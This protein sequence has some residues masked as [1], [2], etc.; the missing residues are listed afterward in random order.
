MITNSRLCSTSEFRGIFPL[1]LTPAISHL[2]A[3]WFKP[4]ADN[5]YERQRDADNFALTLCSGAD[6][7][8]AGYLGDCQ[9]TEGDYLRVFQAYNSSNSDVAKGVTEVHAECP[10]G[11]VVQP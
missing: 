1:S 6:E 9:I 3:T 8:H 4:N 2:P 5:F 7:P 10:I 11:R